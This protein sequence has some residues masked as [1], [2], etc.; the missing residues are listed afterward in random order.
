MVEWPRGEAQDCKSCYTGSNPVST[1]SF[2]IAKTSYLYLKNLVQYSNEVS[3]IDPKRESYFPAIEKKYGQPMS[4]WF[5]QVAG[6]V[7]DKYLEQIAFL[8]ENH[9]FSQ[10]HANALVMYA[11]GSKSSHRFSSVDAYF[12]QFDDV[13]A[14]T[15]RAIFKA[16][17]SKYPKLELVVAWNQPMLRIDGQ[18]IFGVTILKHHLLMAPWSKDVLAQFAS[19]LDGFEVNKKTIRI[20]VDWKV[21]PKLLQDM[22]EVRLAEVA[23]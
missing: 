10:T 19:R 1:S 18:Y 11:R 9:G 4:F 7:T 22:A 17:T 8:R 20:P 5:D 6:I 23:I 16:I 21:D 12:A 15:A 13:R 2:M 14:K 3:E